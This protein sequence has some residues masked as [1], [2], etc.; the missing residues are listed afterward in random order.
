MLRNAC[1]CHNFHYDYGAIC[2]VKAL[3]L[4]FELEDVGLKSC[5]D[6]TST[7]SLK[8]PEKNVQPLRQHHAVN[9]KAFASSRIKKLNS[10]IPWY[11]NLGIIWAT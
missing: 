3:R 11:F 10:Q 2:A 9:G 4:S 1:F 6:R 7:Q 8:I 5:S